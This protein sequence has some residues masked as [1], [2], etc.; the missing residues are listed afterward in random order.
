MRRRSR[1]HAAGDP[2]VTVADFRF[3]PGTTTVQVGQTIT[4]INEGPSA[5][6]ATA[7]DHSFD[8]GVLGK[9]A[10]ASHTFTR[11]GTF[12]Y[13]CSIH[14]FMHGTIV[15]VA[16]ATSTPQ[17]SAASTGPGSPSSPAATTPARPA[18]GSA[19]VPGAPTATGTVGS[20]ALPPTGLELP[21]I[22]GAGL[23]LLGLGLLGAGV[24]ARSARRAGRR[25]PVGGR[26]GC[27][28]PRRH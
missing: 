14:R 18:N 1:A 15:V 19:A 6:T 11:A 9:G 22:A 23:L 16:A 25:E 7:H 24:S 2:G 10:S 4:W 17:R 21:A 8:T 28:P 27:T 20:R 26:E 12:A 5:H 3:A 13:Y